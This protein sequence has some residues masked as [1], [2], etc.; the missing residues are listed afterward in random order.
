MTK[1]FRKELID[2]TTSVLNKLNKSAVNV[3]IS[4]VNN[5]D[6]TITFF[7]NTLRDRESNLYLVLV[8]AGKDDLLLNNTYVIYE[9]DKSLFDHLQ[10]FT[11]KDNYKFYSIHMS[12]LLPIYNE[13]DIASTDAR[14]FQSNTQE[15]DKI[16]S[17]KDE[18]FEMNIRLMKLEHLVRNKL[19]F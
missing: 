5:T 6:E 13:C 10:A 11:G 18:I 4:L 19:K 9:L 12:R 3:G 8:K 14:G 15:P 1:E 16:S 17:L 2:R 7:E